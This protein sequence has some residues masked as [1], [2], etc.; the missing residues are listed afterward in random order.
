[1][2]LTP[3]KMLRRRAQTWE[4]SGVVLPSK[5]RQSG[6]GNK[7]GI[8]AGASHGL[9]RPIPTATVCVDTA[10]TFLQ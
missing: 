7:H 10:I 3:V 1:M 9:P 2:A 4:E 6:K 5:G 8:K